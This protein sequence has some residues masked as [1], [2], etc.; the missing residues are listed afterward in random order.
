M[1]RKDFWARLPLK[2]HIGGEWFQSPSTDSQMTR[3]PK[4]VF[5]WCA[6]VSGKDMRNINDL[7]LEHETLFMRYASTLRDL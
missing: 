6:A 5:R 2:V 7:K 3:A 4:R 1:P